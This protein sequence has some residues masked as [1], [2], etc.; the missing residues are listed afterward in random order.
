MISIQHLT[1]RFGRTVAVEDLTLTCEPGTITGLLGPDGAGKSTTLRV[2]TG[3]SRPTSGTA[4]IGGRPYRE[5]RNPGRVVGSMLDAAAQHPGRT[6]RE[7]LLLAAIA[8]GVPT[9]R[10]GQV[11]ERV[12]L[13]G[14]GG[15]RVAEYSRGM[16]QRLGIGQALVGDPHV[17]VLDEPADGLDPEG[18]AWVRGLLR[19][20]ADAGGTVLVTGHLLPQTAATVDR[21]VLVDR[22]RV[23]DD[24]V[25]RERLGARLTDAAVPPARALLAQAVPA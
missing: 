7:T 18:I 10:V 9:S 21:L 11:L 8:T 12:G 1:K 17:L 24:P 14:A 25:G 4:T 16:R 23:V 5:L 15:R 6:G 19:E 13:D 3:L 20:V 22:G 2:L